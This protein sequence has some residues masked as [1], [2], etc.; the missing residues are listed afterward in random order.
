MSTTTDRRSAAES[1]PRDAKRRLTAAEIGALDPYQLMAELGKTVIHPGGGRSTRE[2]LEMARIQP[3]HRVLDA[4]C[5]IGTSAAQIAQ[6]YGCQVVAV[7]TSRTPTA[8]EPEPR[9]RGPVSVLGSRSARA[10]S[11]GSS[12]RTRASTW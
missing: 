12:S 11:S 10:T 5:G 1:G 8:L 7:D 2:L 6:R 3:H 4:G 9:L